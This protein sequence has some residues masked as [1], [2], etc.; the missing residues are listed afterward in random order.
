[1]YFCAHKGQKTNHEKRGHKETRENLV[2]LFISVARGKEFSLQSVY[3]QKNLYAK[4]DSS[5]QPTSAKICALCG[6]QNF[7]AFLAK[8]IFHAKTLRQK[9]KAQS[10]FNL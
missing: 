2:Q 6:K 5:I 1:M 8:R 3:L 9:A 7:S 4:L 10:Y